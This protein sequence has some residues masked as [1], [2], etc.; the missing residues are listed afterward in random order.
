MTDSKQGPVDDAELAQRLVDQAKAD[1]VSLT[2]PGGLLGGLTKRV[3]ETALEGELDEHLGYSKHGP[4][5][6]DKSN[7]RNEKRSKSVAT[8]VG[9]VDIE[10]PRDR[11]RPLPSSLV[12]GPQ[13]R[14]GARRDDRSSLTARRLQCT[15]ISSRASTSAATPDD[16]AL[17]LLPTLHGHPAL[18]GSA[19]AIR[20]RWVSPSR[21][22]G[23]EQPGDAPRRPRLRP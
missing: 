15:A 18:R 6:R 8:E 12:K 9:P 16:E 11:D 3:L 2:G 21:G 17:P 13:S 1:G 20:S 5:G 23:G 19:R 14:A 7:S 22:L 4:A 10:V